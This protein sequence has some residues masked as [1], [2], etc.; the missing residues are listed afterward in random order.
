MQCLITQYPDLLVY[1][2]D[3]AIGVKDYCELQQLLTSLSAWGPQIGIQFNPSKPEVCFLSF[4]L[5]FFWFRFLLWASLGFGLAPKKHTRQEDNDG[6]VETRYPFNQPRRSHG[7]TPFPQADAS[8]VWI[9]IDQQGGTRSIQSP[10]LPQPS[11]NMRNQPIGF[12]ER[13]SC[14]QGAGLRRQSPKPLVNLNTS[15]RLSDNCSSRFQWIGWGYVQQA[16]SNTS[17]KKGLWTVCGR[18]GLER[19]CETLGLSDALGWGRVKRPLKGRRGPGRQS[20]QATGQRMWQRV[21][22]RGGLRLYGQ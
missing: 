10:Y 7:Y 13:P 3:I 1:R 12:D 15:G 16:S 20:L 6:S 18:D 17:R 2:A 5:S 21:Q 11:G 9:T 8:R 19:I 22:Q 14:W 4:R